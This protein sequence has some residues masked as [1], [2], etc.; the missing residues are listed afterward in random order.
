M[1]QDVTASNKINPIVLTFTNTSENLLEDNWNQFE[2][3]MNTSIVFGSNT[4]WITIQPNETIDMPH[5]VD[6]TII[7]N[8]Y[9][10]DSLNS[11]DYDLIKPFLA[12][13]KRE[14]GEY[15][16]TIEELNLYSFGK[17]LHSVIEELIDDIVDVYEEIN[18]ASPHLGKDPQ[19]WK[20]ILDQ[21]ISVK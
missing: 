15:K 5:L 20:M 3:I 21:H 12:N 16:A 8:K 7:S 1:L 11:S 2:E 18:L 17:N 13:I 9:E 6:P 4:R 19:R 10:I 14:S